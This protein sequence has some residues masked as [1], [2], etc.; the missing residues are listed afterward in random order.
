MNREHVILAI[1]DQFVRTAAWE[2]EVATIEGFGMW[3]PRKTQV[4]LVR[5]TKRDYK[6]LQKGELEWQDAEQFPSNLSN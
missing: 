5:G 6:R 3:S 2:V 4:W 1:V